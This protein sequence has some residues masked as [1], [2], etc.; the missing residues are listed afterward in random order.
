M[1]TGTLYVIA[2]PSGGGKTS[3]V[4]ALIQ[5]VS[6]LVISVSYTTRVQRPGEHHGEN[7]FFVQQAEFDQMVQNE[8]FLEHANVFGH[9]YGTAR[10]WVMA[11]LSRDHDVI[12]E[13]DWQGAQ[14]I[15]QLFPAVVSIFIVPPS[16][17]AL[18]HRLKQRGQ[19][20][21]DVINKRMA[22]ARSEMSHWPEFDYLVIND[23][24]SI[25]L[26]ELVSIV[27]SQRCVTDTQAT[28]HQELLSKLV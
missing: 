2:A 10:D 28:R 17:S 11:Q 26:N 7:Y 25:A 20:D 5:R 14:Q 27:L 24:F 1:S 22:Q 4:N 18:E 13:I 23:D 9:S 16:L 12:L 3:L 8:Q 21:E 6:N 15:R 19:D